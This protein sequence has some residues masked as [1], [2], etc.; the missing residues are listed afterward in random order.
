MTG[1]SPEA[2]NSGVELEDFD[3]EARGLL[4]REL[5][6]HDLYDEYDP[7]VDMI[8]RRL[9]LLC[10]DDIPRPQLY[11]QSEIEPN[12]SAG[13]SDIVVNDGV[14]K[15]LR[16]AEEL[17]ALLA[18]ELTHTR[19]GHNGII[20]RRGRNL[21]GKLGLY[22]AAETE[23]DLGGMLL[24]DRRGIN[25]L[26]M[27]RLMETMQLN[28]A[29]EEC[30]SLYERIKAAASPTHGSWDNRKTNLEEA[31]KLADLRH[32]SGTFTSPAELQKLLRPKERIG[33]SPYAGESRLLKQH[34][35]LRQAVQ[36][37]TP[38]IPEL[39][40]QQ[41]R[42]LD[43]GSLDE[44]RL[45]LQAQL[46]INSQLNQEVRAGEW[47]PASLD[48]LEQARQLLLA[49][50]VVAVVGDAF[51]ND[52]SAL[53]CDFVVRVVK[54][55]DTDAPLA[56]DRTELV[57]IG[58]YIEEHELEGAVQAAAETMA[59]ERGD[60]QLTNDQA[61]TFASVV[62]NT[63][64]H[65]LDVQGSE[66]KITNM[67]RTERFGQLAYLA[68]DPAQL[69][70]VLSRY[71]SE[72]LGRALDESDDDGMFDKSEYE[73]L[74]RY[75]YHGW[76]LRQDDDTGNESSEELMPMMISIVDSAF[77]NVTPAQLATSL[78]ELYEADFG[79]E[80]RDIQA[81]AK[82]GALLF[83]EA[84]QAQVIAPFGFEDVIVLHALGNDHELLSEAY[85]Q[86]VN[87]LFADLTGRIIESPKSIVWSEG[88]GTQEIELAL[89]H[90][91][92]VS[93]LE[94]ACESY[95]SLR[96]HVER[97]LNRYSAF[98]NEDMLAAVNKGET[99]RQ[100]ETLRAIMEAHYS[101]EGEASRLIAALEHGELTR[102]TNSGLFADQDIH[103]AIMR[104]TT[105][106]TRRLLEVPL[107]EA[108]EERLLAFVALGIILPD[109]ETNLVIPA[110]ALAELTSRKS[111]TEGLE[112]ITKRF[113]HLPSYVLA[114]SYEMLVE[115]KAETME[116]FEKLAEANE[117][118]L[119]RM[120]EE[121]QARIGGMSIVETMVLDE[122]RGLETR[123]RRSA[124]K[125]DVVRGMEAPR[126]LEA[127]LSTGRDDAMLKEYLAE[128]WWLA[129][130]T[131]PLVGDVED[132][133]KVEALTYLRHPGKENRLKHWL[134]RDLPDPGTYQPLRTILDNVYLS[135]SAARYMVVRN[136][137]LGEG[138]VLQTEVGRADLVHGIMSSWIAEDDPGRRAV[139]R[140]L[141]QATLDN[142]E[143]GEVYA[144][145]SPVLRSM[146]L[147][148]PQ[149]ECSFEMLA[150]KLAETSLQAMVERRLIIKPT[151]RDL[152]MLKQRI[153]LL[154]NGPRFH[155][156]LK[157]MKSPLFSYF[158]V[159]EEQADFEELSTGEFAYRV[160]KE[161]GALGTR[162]LQ[163]ALQYFELT[164]EERAKFS[165]VYD[166]TVGQSRLQ[167]VNTLKRE[168]RYAA[169]VRDLLADTA[170]I[171]KRLG[172]GSLMTVYKVHLKD[173]S[174]E[175]IGVRNPNAEYHVAKIAG[176]LTTG[177]DH[178]LQA[179]PDHPNLRLIESLMYDVVQWIRDELND[180]DFTR[181]D[182]QFRAENDTTQN[183]GRATKGDSRYDMY[184]PTAT[185]T[186]T[187]WIRREE[188]VDGKNF[189][190]LTVTRGRTNIAKG[191]INTEDNKDVVAHLTR[192]YLKQLT[193]GTVTHSDIHPGNFRITFDNSKIVVFDR[194]NLLEIDEATRAAVHAVIAGIAGSNPEMVVDAISDYVTAD[195][196]TEVSQTMRRQIV[197]ILSGG[198]QA[199]EL[200]AKIMVT[201]KRHGVQ[202]PL[203]LSLIMRNVLVLQKMSAE[204]G[205]ANVLEAVTY[206]R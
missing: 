146:I 99:V 114:A 3:R 89:D 161:S 53:A 108:S 84:S 141:L 71:R 51:A 110:A 74:L 33:S 145:L 196:G 98:V 151:D 65:A 147:R 133:F 187:P 16:S 5:Y 164:P 54:S 115:Q 129:N 17:D 66:G 52:F 202:V 26:A 126:L 95:A 58:N 132:H 173:G 157:G 37:Q 116:D 38:Q 117:G 8:G 184:V 172:G 179:E 24:L 122:Y 72:K 46:I 181:K 162:M 91:S 23:A 12:A 7:L 156:G 35:L 206:K 10:G 19:K 204:A 55:T 176:L 183:G 143:A 90:T 148:R 9:D 174:K 96:Q 155:A 201:L 60:S 43:D 64:L 194:Y 130:R 150:G 119:Q 86:R 45:T 36:A 75:E 185:P 83:S 171:G 166:N 106:L 175:V 118:W 103:S 144:Y 158:G 30:G 197:E 2:Q 178:V 136:T 92:V 192:S 195:T 149:E 14:L 186:D 73:P 107:E 82:L 104:L 127:L 160:A 165:D 22:R 152:D 189:N 139:L 21:V 180:T 56:G 57:K 142:N 112:L 15:V 170:R 13:A 188:F 88:S 41:K 153:L 134:N 40:E 198:G 182:T 200:M 101:Q 168:A 140:A 191:R 123:E 109:V 94:S 79:V 167:A 121:H 32:A 81:A 34:A 31:I 199:T 137:L 18:H 70:I 69:L 163:L 169:G 48:D 135:S 67:I 177:I 6:E 44:A 154:M 42:L 80:A 78:Q 28:S 205:F 105:E 120:I 159:V 4:F 47:Q 63:R 49:P 102:L 20:R 85:D 29:A 190:A 77:A 203:K 25:P 131:D 62:A 113:A 193:Q 97:I 128:R 100:A 59:D 124:L 39:V 87:K 61:A 27:V 50:N 76:Q 93:A 68:D 138:G 11:V 125:T 1:I 111:F